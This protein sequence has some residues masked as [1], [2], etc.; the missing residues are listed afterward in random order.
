MLFTY[1]VDC[2]KCYDSGDAI[3]YLHFFGAKHW[4]EVATKLMKL[5]L[6]PAISR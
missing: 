3:S 6:L 4:S 2:P 5:V 1:D